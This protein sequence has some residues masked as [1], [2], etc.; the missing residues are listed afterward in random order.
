MQDYSESKFF[1]SDNRD[2]DG[3]WECKEFKD[4]R[5]IV[6]IYSTSLTYL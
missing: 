4:S 1:H 5:E 6:D 2:M 3:P